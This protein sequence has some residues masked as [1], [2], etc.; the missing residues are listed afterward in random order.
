MVDK[1]GVDQPVNKRDVLVIH[2]LY[3]IL[4]IALF[5]SDMVFLRGN[6]NHR[7]FGRLIWWSPEGL[8][9][10]NVLV[11]SVRHSA[12]VDIAMG[13]DPAAVT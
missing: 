6:L 4:K 1:V 8:T 10:A 9:L 3:E 12:Q 13:V 5:S 7:Y 11:D 2:P